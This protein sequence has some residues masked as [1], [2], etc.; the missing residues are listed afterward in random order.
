MFCVVGTNLRMP[1]H[2]LGGAKLTRL[3]ENGGFDHSFLLGSWRSKFKPKKLSVCI[4]HMNNI[5][6]IWKNLNDS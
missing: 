1:V 3:V 6:K 4:A 2:I 5:L